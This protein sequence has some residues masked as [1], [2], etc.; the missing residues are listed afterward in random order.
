MTDTSATNETDCSEHAMH[1]RRE[2]DDRLTEEKRHDETLSVRTSN[3]R[4]EQS[5]ANA[6]AGEW[7]TD[8]ARYA[9]RRGNERKRGTQLKTTWYDSRE[10][11]A[12]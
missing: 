4:R 5:S 8:D 3:E 2:E 10:H 7:R 1:A 11:V 9:H 6:T 12:S